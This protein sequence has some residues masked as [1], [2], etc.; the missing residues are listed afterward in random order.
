MSPL[1]CDWIEVE[2]EALAINSL[3]EWNIASSQSLDYT[4][5]GYLVLFE[6]TTIS[7]H[8]T[9]NEE[10]LI[11]CLDVILLVFLMKLLE[12]INLNFSLMKFVIKSIN[13]ASK[14]LNLTH[15]T[16]W[17]NLS[18]VFKVINEGIIEIVGMAES[19][20]SLWETILNL[21]VLS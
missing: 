13:D 19:E 14:T 15:V 12:V 17:S 2:I 16:N 7:P 20:Y 9:E 3:W 10:C 4:T 5:K 6:G 11:N 18:L 8:E 21:F 1:Q